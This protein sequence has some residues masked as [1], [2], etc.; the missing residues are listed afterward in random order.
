[1]RSAKIGIDIVA[2]LAFSDALFNCDEC[3]FGF[4]EIQDPTKSN[5]DTSGQSNSKNPGTCGKEKAPH[6]AGALVFV[7]GMHPPSNG[8][9]VLLSAGV[10]VGA[11]TNVALAGRVARIAFVG[12]C[13][14][15]G[16]RARLHLAGLHFA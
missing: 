5:E 11:G 14:H 2:P 3:V 6:L 9:C 1:M 16:S 7:E 8:E 13:T 10:A 4:A 12:T 15:S